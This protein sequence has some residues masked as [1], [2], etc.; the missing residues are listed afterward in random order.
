MTDFIYRRIGLPNE[1]SKR[2]H[3]DCCENVITFSGIII[4]K[5]R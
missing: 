2:I 4:D 1:R 3:W 5:G